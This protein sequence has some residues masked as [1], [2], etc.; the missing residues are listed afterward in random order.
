MLIISNNKT[1]NTL[2][3]NI[4]TDIKISKTQIS[5]IIQSGGS[6]GYSLA[7]SGRK[8][9]TNVAIPLARDNLPGLVSNLTL[10]AMN[11]FDRKISRKG[12]GRA[13][14]G[15]ALFISNEDMDDIIKIVKSFEDLGVLIAEVTETV[16]HEIKKQSKKA[17]FLELC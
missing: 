12:A 10:S 15:F 8:A 17:G 13:R 9:L 2:A 5:K 3:G 6:F 16:K 11:K 4:S 7:N 14:K 1:I